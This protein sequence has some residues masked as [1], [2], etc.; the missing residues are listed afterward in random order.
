MIAAHV[1]DGW[2][3]DP[4]PANCLPV[5]LDALEEPPRGLLITHIHLDHAG[6]AGTLARRFPEMPVYVHRIGATHLAD[7]SRLLLSAGR[8]YGPEKMQRLWGEVLPVDPRNLRPLDGGERIGPLGK[9]L[10]LATPGHASHHIAYLHEESGA[11]FTGD[12][13]GVRIADSPIVMPTP[14]PDIDL[15]AWRRSIWQ[16]SGHDPQSLHLTHFGTV[17]DPRTHFEAALAELD[18]IERLAEAGREAFDADVASR[19]EAL[20]EDLR[21]SLAAAATPGHL[22]LGMERFLR[23]R[24]DKIASSGGPAAR[25][26]GPDQLP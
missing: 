2:L 24:E 22:Y 7:P 17:V 8:L 5:L 23:K 16:L 9:L 26:D 11:A 6:A 4:G 10:A 18:R 15:A 14:P 12:V 19:L 21:A 25:A 1:V 20:D 3:I 13:A